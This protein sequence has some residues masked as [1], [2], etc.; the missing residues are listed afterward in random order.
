M[1]DD[2]LSSSSMSFNR[3]PNN[4]KPPKR[5]GKNKQQPTTFM[6]EDSLQSALSNSVAKQLE[7]E[8]EKSSNQVYRT[9]AS[10]NYD[11]RT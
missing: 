10:R 4:F 8:L 7:K 6:R 5:K 11:N 9:A 3:G 2:L 1:F